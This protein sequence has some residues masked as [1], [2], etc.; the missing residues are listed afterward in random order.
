MRY[1]NKQLAA[2]C[3][4]D[5]F[6]Q[7]LVAFFLLPSVP[8]V[9]GSTVWCSGNDYGARQTNQISLLQ[10]LQRAMAEGERSHSIPSD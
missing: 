8:P 5:S 7:L 4:S 6:Y 10:R 1:L 2:F 3:S 9:F